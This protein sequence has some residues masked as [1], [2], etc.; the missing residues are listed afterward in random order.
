MN[1][2]EGRSVS[3]SFTECSLDFDREGRSRLM[4]SH[5]VSNAVGVSVFLNVPE[6]RFFY[7]STHAAPGR[8]RYY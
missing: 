6:W 2:F 3:G 4:R 1:R 5:F 8:V 7:V